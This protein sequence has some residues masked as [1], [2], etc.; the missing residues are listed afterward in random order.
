MCFFSYAVASFLVS[1]ICYLLFQYPYQTIESYI[2][3]I[4]KE[5]IWQVEKSSNS[6]EALKAEK[7]ENLEKKTFEEK[8]LYSR[9]VQSNIFTEVH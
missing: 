8:V 6:T 9:Y 5:N 4:D 3:G 1:F 7:T 2:F